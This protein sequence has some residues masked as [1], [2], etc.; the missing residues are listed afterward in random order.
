MTTLSYYYHTV[1]GVVIIKRATLSKVRIGGTYLNKIKSL[2]TNPQPM[3][4]SK[5]KS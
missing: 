4:Y 3:Q 2:M 1:L 5:V